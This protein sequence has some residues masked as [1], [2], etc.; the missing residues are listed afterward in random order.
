MSENWQA[1]WRA[2]HPREK[3]LLL[4][5]AAFVTVAVLYGLIWQPGEKARARYAKSVPILR[6]QLAQMREQA[7]T[8]QHLRR[9]TAL[10]PNSAHLRDDL[11]ASAAHHRLPNDT[12]TLTVSPTGDIHLQMHNISFD[13]WVSW[14]AALQRENHLRLT[15]AQIQTSGQPGLVNIDA[16]L[17]SAE[18][19]P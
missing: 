11:L 5:G 2:R 6:A 7:T 15:M 18:N 4:L 13:D 14:L 12:R 8:I 1:F 19:Q 16:T 3:V 10:L 17:I 9:Q